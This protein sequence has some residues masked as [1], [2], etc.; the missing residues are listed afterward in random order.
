MLY[1]AE[2]YFFS[3]LSNHLDLTKISYSD[4]KN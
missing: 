1:K 2:C 3:L 4:P